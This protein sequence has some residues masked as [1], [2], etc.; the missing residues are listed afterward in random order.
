MRGKM[1]VIATV[2]VKIIMP[3]GMRQKEF[4]AAVQKHFLQFSAV[5]EL[6]LIGK[7]V[8]YE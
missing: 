1:Q 3:S 2:R 4:M 6:K 5:K 8:K 7:E